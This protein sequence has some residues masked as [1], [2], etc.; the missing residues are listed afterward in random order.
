MELLEYWKGQTNVNVPD[1]LSEPNGFLGFTSL[2][3]AVSNGHSETLDLLLTFGANI[4]SKANGYT[5]LHVAAANGH[6]DCIRVLIRHGADTSV[7]DQFQKTAIDTAVIA[8]RTNIVKILNSA[9]LYSYTMHSSG[10]ID[11]LVKYMVQ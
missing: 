4:N 3:E 9:G 7:K 6:T 2:H 10:T 11:D 8:A 1:K 5:P